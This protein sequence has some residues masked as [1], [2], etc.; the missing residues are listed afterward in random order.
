MLNFKFRNYHHKKVV[1]E[2]KSLSITANSEKHKET[3]I[4]WLK[5]ELQQAKDIISQIQKWIRKYKA[6]INPSNTS[7][8]VARSSGSTSVS[9]N[10]DW[11]VI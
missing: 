2:L 4:E 11:I 10:D 3:D 8:Q 6:E 5:N 9:K 7:H 1:L